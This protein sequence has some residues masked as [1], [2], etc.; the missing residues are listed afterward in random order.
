LEVLFKIQNYGDIQDGR[1][2]I[3]CSRFVKNDT[4]NLQLRN[5]E[6]YLINIIEQFFFQTAKWLNNSK[7]RRSFLNHNFC[8]LLPIFKPNHVLEA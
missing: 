8:I 2:T 5:L 1:Q 4:N 7:W 3:K 6:D